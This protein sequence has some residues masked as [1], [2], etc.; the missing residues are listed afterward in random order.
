MKISFTLAVFIILSDKIENYFLYF[1]TTTHSLPGKVETYWTPYGRFDRISQDGSL[2]FCQNGLVQ[3]VLPDPYSAELHYLLPIAVLGCQG[4]ILLIRGTPAVIYSEP[5][6]RTIPDTLYWVEPNHFLQRLYFSG[7]NLQKLDRQLHLL[8]IPKGPRRYLAS[9]NKTHYDLI[10]MHLS[11]PATLV[12]N[13]YYTEE[14]FQSVGHA[15]SDSG[16]FYFTLPG[17][18]NLL[19]QQLSRF[20]GTIKRTAESVFKYVEILPGSEA[21][22]FCSNRTPPEPLYRMLINLE[23]YCSWQPTTLN[24]TYWFYRLSEERL[25][26]FNATLSGI[27][28]GPINTDRNFLG[29]IRYIQTLPLPVI[30]K[31]GMIIESLIPRRFLL[32]GII[33]GLLLMSIFLIRP[34]RRIIAGLLTNGLLCMSL[35]TLGLILYQIQHGNIYQE[36]ALFIGA[37]MGGMALGVHFFSRFSAGVWGKILLRSGYS[38]IAV[39][40]FLLFNLNIAFWPIL[41]VRAAFTFIF[42]F[43]GFSGGFWFAALSKQFTTGGKAPGRSYAWDLL[44]A[45]LGTFIF[46][47]LLLPVLG[48]ELFLLILAGTNLI[49]FTHQKIS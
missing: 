10:I 35:E 45:A 8:N 32:A 17:A 26:E 21:I 29:F 3:S 1:S 11:P 43:S 42:V 18:E 28:E 34:E 24:K 16:A 37:F 48:T 27:E 12:A 30:R 7:D 33:L 36:T 47:T 41:P 2:T 40:L 44:G 19:S 25:S 23:D 13:A 6:P 14:F 49:I 20:L 22:F 9:E 4:K 31:L 46:T 39:I 15:L 38:F 5:L